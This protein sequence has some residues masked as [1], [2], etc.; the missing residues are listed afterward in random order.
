MH[1]QHT[2]TCIMKVC[3]AMATVY[4][5]T[6]STCTCMAIVSLKQLVVY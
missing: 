5:P 3:I 1:L 2:P 4:V 6:E